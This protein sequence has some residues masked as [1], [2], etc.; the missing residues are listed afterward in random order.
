[1]LAFSSW[2]GLLCC[3]KDCICEE[4]DALVETVGSVDICA[5]VVRSVAEVGPIGS[6]EVRAGFHAE[7]FEHPIVEI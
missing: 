4:L 5:E 3:F 7:D 2:D 1:M 6:F